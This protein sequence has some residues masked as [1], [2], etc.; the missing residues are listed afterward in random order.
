MLLTWIVI[1]Q[2]QYKMAKRLKE[3]T[4]KPESH[5][6]E[7][8]GEVSGGHSVVKANGPKPTQQSQ[9]GGIEQFEALIVPPEVS[10]T[11][12]QKDGTSKFVCQGRQQDFMQV[13]VRGVNSGRDSFCSISSRVSK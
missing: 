10:P 12:L 6:Y 8:E 11:A 2:S 13:K 1:D 9:K 5:Q 7:T 3:M 4:G